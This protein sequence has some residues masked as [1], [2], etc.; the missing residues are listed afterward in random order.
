MKDF[1]PLRLGAVTVAKIL[2]EIDRLPLEL[3]D[4]RFV[5]VADPVT[6]FLDVG[7]GDSDGII[8]LEI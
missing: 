5:N 8:V 7:E 2:S 1:W 3:D 6:E 4:C